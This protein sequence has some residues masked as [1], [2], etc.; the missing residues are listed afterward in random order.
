MPTR[1][2]IETLIDRSRALERGGQIAAALQAAREAQEMAQ[3][4]GEVD[5]RDQARVAQAQAFFRLGDYAEARR[6]CELALARG[7]EQQ[8][9]VDALRLLGIIALE[10]DEMSAGEAYLRRVVALT[11][12]NGD[13]M[14][15]ARTLHNLSAG[16]YMPRGQF[17]LSLAHDEEAQ[18][19]LR[20]HAD[21]PEAM[22]HHWAT[23][24]TPIWVHWLCGRNARAAELLEELQALVILGSLGDAYVHV[25]RAGLALDAGELEQAE[26]DLVQALSIA[27]RLGSPEARFQARMG[28]SRQ[29]RLAGDASAALHW[30]E[31]ALT[32]AATQGYA[33]LRGMALIERGRAHEGLGE[34]PTAAADYRAALGELAP[35]ELDFD[36]ARAELLLAGATLSA[37]DWRAALQTITRGGFWFLFDQERALGLRLLAQHFE[38]AESVAILQRLLQLPAPPLRVNTLGGL[39]VSLRGRTLEKNALRQRGA[40]ELLGVLLLA[41]GRMLAYEQIAEALCP[42]KDPDAARIFIQHAVSALRRALEPDLPDRRFPSRY[43]EAGEGR[44][45]LRL[46]PGSTLDYEELEAACAQKRWAEALENYRGEFLPEFRYAEWAIPKR[47]EL[48]MLFQRALLAV[49]EA[50][51]AGE[52]FPAGLAAAE[53][54]LALDGWNER[55]AW[56]AMRCAAALGDVSGA[57]RRYRA[58]EQTLRSELGIAPS[59][60]LQALEREIRGQ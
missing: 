5:L 37:E 23:L 21:T 12:R 49:G 31:D 16:V 51:L 10:T 40:G 3:V 54:L 58:L 39:Q 43:L 48:S 34:L 17:E 29:R 38:Q 35:L 18:R 6:L 60:E 7:E 14:M 45:E 9:G 27:E 26:P 57:L 1:Q 42:D 44:L 32:V 53:R 25:I 41:P 19:I 22:S 24:T 30:A 59:P 56:I 46:P 52:N 11:R 47:E 4:A 8:A 50:E 13:D 2:Q 15:L 36:R 55:A 28:R 33:H 20:A